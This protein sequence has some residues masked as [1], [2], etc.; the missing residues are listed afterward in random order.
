MTRKRSKYND[1]FGLHLNVFYFYIYE[2]S[3][4]MVLTIENVDNK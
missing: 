3:A 4:S 2:L 1:D